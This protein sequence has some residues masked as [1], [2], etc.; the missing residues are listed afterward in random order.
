MPKK[1]KK[2]GGA[3]AGTPRTPSTP[4]G[5]PGSSARRGGVGG[6]SNLGTP[7]AFFNAAEKL[8]ILEGGAGCVGTVVCAN[9][10]RDDVVGLH[11]AV[12]QAARFRLG[13]TV[14]FWTAAQETPS[15]LVGQE[16]ANSA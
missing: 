10:H 4:K 12:M 13:Q 2:Q 15:M 9:P 3:G 1:K 16:E 6:R 14:R 5:T 11:P 8:T 7:P